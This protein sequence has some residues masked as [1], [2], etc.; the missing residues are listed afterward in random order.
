MA[1]WDSQI[2]Q[3]N[4]MSQSVKDGLFS[5]MKTSIPTLDKINIEGIQT[6]IV[7]DEATLQMTT[8]DFKH[9]AKVTL[10]KEDGVWKIEEES[11]K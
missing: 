7:D 11:W 10:L 2:A 9:S 1:F 8:K 4:A 3:Y 6:Q 5:M